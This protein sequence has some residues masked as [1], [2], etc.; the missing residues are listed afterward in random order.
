[1]ENPIITVLKESNHHSKSDPYSLGSWDQ[2][3]DDWV[4]PT[5]GFWSFAKAEIHTA[6][7]V[8]GCVPPFAVC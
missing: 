1:M 3:S 8:R 7:A 4:T 6:T 2:I 5:T